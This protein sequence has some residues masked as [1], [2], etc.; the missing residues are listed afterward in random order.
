VIA[1]GGV[2]RPLALPAVGGRV[3]VPFPQVPDREP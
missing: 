2:L 3:D 1:A